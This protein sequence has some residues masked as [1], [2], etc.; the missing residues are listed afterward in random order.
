MKQKL[1][2]SIFVLGILSFSVNAQ[3][4]EKEK[5]YELGA[6]LKYWMAG[7]MY[8]IGDSEKEGGVFLNAYA[9]YN[10]VRKFAIGAYINYGPSFKAKDVDTDG[11]FFEK[12]LRKAD[13]ALK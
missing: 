3:D 6:S 9:D 12:G 7:D 2:L 5:E 13:G 8:F 11:N 4:V 1:L 10:I